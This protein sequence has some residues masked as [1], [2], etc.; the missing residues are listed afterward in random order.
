MGAMC[1]VCFAVFLWTASNGRIVWEEQLTWNCYA[2]GGIKPILRGVEFGQGIRVHREL[3]GP[4][5]LEQQ[6]SGDI[7]TSHKKKPATPNTNKTQKA[8][9]TTQHNK[10]CALERRRGG[11]ARCLGA[12]VR[13]EHHH[14]PVAQP[15]FLQIRQNGA[16][17]Q[18][19]IQAQGTR[20]LTG[21][22]RCH[23]FV[24]TSNRPART[25]THESHAQPPTS[26]PLF[27]Y[28]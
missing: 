20:P 9:A 1:A 18:A 6:R 16:D 13:I 25:H 21:T 27:G 11:G 14:S 22:N 4:R 26:T 15:C 12:V 17:L 28:N 19:L 7:Q 8:N 23:I 2:L 10:T 5:R 24:T 3:Q